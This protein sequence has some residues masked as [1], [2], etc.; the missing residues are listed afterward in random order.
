MWNEDPQA[1]G[2]TY[3]F[4]STSK[5]MFCRWVFV[6]ALDVSRADV[7]IYDSS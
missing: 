4:G 7:G 3:I 5:R 1:T 6:S 2:F